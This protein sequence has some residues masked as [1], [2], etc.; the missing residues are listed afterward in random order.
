MAFQPERASFLAFCS[1]VATVVLTGKDRTRAGI[2]ARF[3][4]E[5]IFGSVVYK[6]STYLSDKYDAESVDHQK[7]V[8][9]LESLMCR[10][11]GQYRPV[12]NRVIV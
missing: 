6:S 4:S 3:T 8:L 1:L 9:E 7:N 10:C 12:Q 11:G 2:P 5:E